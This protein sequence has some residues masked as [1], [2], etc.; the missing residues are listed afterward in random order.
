MTSLTLNQSRLLLEPVDL[1]IALPGWLVRRFIIICPTVLIC[2]AIA[3]KQL[4]IESCG[5]CA[6]LDK[7]VFILSGNYG[8]IPNLLCL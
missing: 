6:F 3:F 1:S 2:L 7:A 5:C 4:T 8:Y